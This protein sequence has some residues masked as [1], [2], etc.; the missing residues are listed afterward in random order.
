MTITR[1]N[2]KI[3]IIT[4]TDNRLRIDFAVAG[5]IPNAQNHPRL[6]GLFAK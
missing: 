1:P 5:E 6:S 2:N 3:T 4:V